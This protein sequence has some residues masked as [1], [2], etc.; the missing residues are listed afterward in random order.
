M[1]SHCSKRQKF[2]G[3]VRVAPPPTFLLSPFPLTLIASHLLHLFYALM[4][5][6]SQGRVRAAEK[7]EGR[8]DD[9][10]LKLPKERRRDDFYKFA[11]REGETRTH[12]T[13]FAM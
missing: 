5:S 13:P 6:L 9:D 8:E 7:G 1:L 3:V 10:E 11:G 2:S 4:D 12:L